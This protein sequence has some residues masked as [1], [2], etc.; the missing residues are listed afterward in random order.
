[1]LPA[2]QRLS[3]KDFMSVHTGGQFFR[4]KMCS[5]RVIEKV[6]GK[7]R[8]GVVVSKK[9]SK[10]AVTRHVVKRRV[11]VVLRELQSVFNQPID[12]IVYVH[13]KQ[14]SY[15]YSCLKIDIEKALRKNGY[16]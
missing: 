2:K 5:F 12:I 9:V 15:K 7:M 10:I 1:M 8:A 4:G 14:D 13:P 11:Y 6:E 3:R 16:V